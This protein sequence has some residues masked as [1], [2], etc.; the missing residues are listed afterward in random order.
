MRGV[1]RLGPT[2]LSLAL[3]GVITLAAYADPVLLAAA[4]VL[5]QVL[6]AA[7]PPLLTSAGAV[8]TSP[9]FAPAVVAGVVATVLTLEPELLDGAEGTS[10]DVIGP[11]DTGTLAGVL[12]AIVA[13]LFVALAGQMLRKDGRPQ[14]VQSLAYA[15]TLAVLAAF[16][17]GWIGT[18]RSLGD[19]DA[20]AVAAAGLGAGLLAWAVPIDRWVCLGL[21]TL[22]GAAGGAA[23][24]ATVDAS[25]TV[26]FGVVV[27]AAA[28]LFAV[29]G[30]VAARAMA[31]GSLQP[32]ARWGFPGAVAV[33]FV[34][35]VA[36][37]GGQLITVPALR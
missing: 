9:R 19:A 23:V 24:A 5:V 3:A 34:A 25:M 15:V 26:Y 32:A 17:A 7:G 30:Q 28:A 35:P 27:G 33:A 13:G 12:P 29:L 6:V 37:L 2:L 4:V 20:V 18:L 31:G 22:A 21:S 36:Y 8:I 1:P 10:F 16:A 14:L 11:T